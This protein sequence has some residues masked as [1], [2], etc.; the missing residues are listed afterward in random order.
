MTL[1]DK[2]V[3]LHN[4]L[5]S[6][7]LPHAF[8]GAL[9]LAWCTGQ[10]RGTIDID[11]NV[12]VG[13]EQLDA[14]LAA[15]PNEIAV[16]PRE[17]KLLKRDGQARLWW[18]ST[19]VDVFLNVLPYHDEVGR[20]IRWEDFAGARVPFL[21]CRDLAVFKAFF[22]RTRDWADIEAMQDAGTLDVRYVRA[23]LAELLGAD[24]ERLE[25]LAAVAAR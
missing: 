22:S 15:L 19:P 3:S 23:V 20:Q 2:I 25:K 1:A 13:V 12:F 16:R 10:A 11:V 4:S 21:A 14:L 18:D 9:A 17:E 8:G 5:A 7:E 6:A 24:D